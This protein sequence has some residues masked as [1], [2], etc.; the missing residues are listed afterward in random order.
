[1]NNRLISVIL[2][3]SVGVIMV[4][5]VLVPTIIDANDDTK[6]YYNNNY[7]AFAD[8]SD[9]EEINLEITTV[10]GTA[11]SSTYYINGE[12]LNLIQGSRVIVVSENLTIAQEHATGIGITGVDSSG[13]LFRYLADSVNVAINGESITIEWVRSVDSTSGTINVNSSWIFYRSFDGDWRAVE[14]LSSSRTAY[15]NDFSQ[16]Y[17]SN[18]IGTTKEFFTLN[19]TSVEVYSGTVGET[20]TLST[21][22]ATVEATEVMNGV[23]SFVI[24]SDRETSGA[25]KFTVDNEGEPYDVFPYYFI[26][27]ASVYGQTDTNIAIATILFAIPVIVLLSFVV[28]IVR[29]FSNND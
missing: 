24:S 16:V 1:M 27:P 8:V 10:I 23:S 12:E 3:I 28:F 7:G 20:A 21:T 9:N 18:W 5:S 22:T 2:A 15:I 17:S 29:T 6:V 4:G 25:F 19:G 11:G 14:Y 13:N 26:I